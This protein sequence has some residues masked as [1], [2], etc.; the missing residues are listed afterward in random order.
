MATSKT[1]LSYGALLFPGF[2]VLDIAGPL[3]A[4]N[5]LS[6]LDG[7][8]NMTLSVIARSM[9][10]LTPAAPDGKGKNFTSK[11]LYLPTHTFDNAPQ[12]DVLLVPG[13][14]GTVNRAD[15][16]AEVDFIKKVYRGEGCQPLQYLFTVCTGSRLA[17]QGGSIPISY[18]MVLYQ[19]PLG[20]CCC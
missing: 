16:T 9:D 7:Q 14:Q 4:L 8:E 12:I 15:T 10:P 19:S 17:A 3:E 20:I 2:E 5:C 6:M 1:P 18:F 13:G 11:Q